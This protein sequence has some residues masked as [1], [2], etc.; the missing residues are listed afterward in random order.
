M[1]LK[2]IVVP[3]V[4]PFDEAGHVDTEALK[5]LCEFLIE[6]GVHGLYPCG[7]TGEAVLLTTEERKLIAKVVV[8]QTGG[9]IPVFVHVGAA[10]TGEA[11]ELAKHA[12]E[13]GADGIAA[14]T[15]FYFGYSQEA[16]IQY[17][18]EILAVVPADY[19]VYLYNIPGCTGNDLLPKSVQ[20]LAEKYPNIIGIKNSMPDLIRA[21]EY[22]E[23]RENFSVVLGNDLLIAP[24]VLVGCDGAVSGNAQV[25]PE[26]FVKL[27]E[28]AAAK[29]VETAVEL[30]KK[31]TLV[32]KLL[33][34]GGD[35]SLF[36]YGLAHRGVPVGDVRAPLKKVDPQEAAE[37]MAK[38]DELAVY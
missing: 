12:V 3:I 1:R 29:D 18:E 35:L 30:Q 26:L 19:P 13:I 9:R 16:L 36:K 24:G 4:T 31:A 15:P 5:N 10:T 14:V 25:A 6:K 32:A 22:I 28:A 27:Y 38:I 20:Y 7:T 2:G 8:E 34:N 37:I 23:C 11:V 17:Y 33:R 21:M